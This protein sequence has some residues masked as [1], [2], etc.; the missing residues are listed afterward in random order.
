MQQERKTQLSNDLN[1]AKRRALHILE[2]SDRTEQ[3]LRDKLSENYLPEVVDAA[4]EYVKSYHY[5]DDHRY[6]VNYLNSRGRVKS[7]RQ[8]EQ[9]LLYKKG[10]SKAVL[11]EA[12][13]E[14]E[15][16]D[17]RVQIRRWMEKKHMDPVNAAPEEKRR[18]YQFLLRR[19]FRSSD[20][21]AEL[22]E[23]PSD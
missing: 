13:E 8:I 11:E 17:E 14:A 10:I 1:R 19:G 16:Q 12:R 9:E 20:I 18:F 4:V 5:I 6:A 21:L 3:E 23:N 7:S 15:P 2:R 22:R